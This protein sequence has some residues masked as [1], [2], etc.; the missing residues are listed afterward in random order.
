VSIVVLPGFDFGEGLCLRCSFLIRSRSIS[1][2]V[3]AVSR[4]AEDSSARS[5]AF[6]ADFLA[7]TMAKNKVAIETVNG[8]SCDIEKVREWNR[9]T[10][11]KSMFGER[12]V[13]HAAAL[14]KASSERPMPD[15]LAA[16][17]SGLSVSVLGGSPG[18]FSA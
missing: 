18:V 6:L 4:V 12:S 1:S 8:Q 3:W 16:D 5:S 13:L 15:A 7:I 14:L 17:D 11:Y 10:A 2:F 9:G